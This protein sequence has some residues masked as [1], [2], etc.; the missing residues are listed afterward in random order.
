MCNQSVGLIQRVFDEA[1]L[2]TISLTLVR[3][4]TELVKPSRALYIRHPFGYTFGD[5]HDRQV[6]RAILVD[7]VRAAERFT[8]PGT[9]VELPYRWTKNDL[10][11]KQLLKRAH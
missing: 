10:R 4:I 11:E 1:G 9:I 2:T 3:S 6:Q 5:L 7:C 8:E